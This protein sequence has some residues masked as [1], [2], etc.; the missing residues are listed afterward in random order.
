MRMRARHDQDTILFDESM[1]YNLRYGKL[2][3][4]RADALDAAS[5]VGLDPTAQ[6]MPY[7]YDTRVGERGLTLSGGERQRVAIARAL[8]KDPP[9]MLYD[10]ATSVIA[11]PWLSSL[12]PCRLSSR[13]SSCLPSRP[14]PI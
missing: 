8:L 2:E 6:K 13:L 14:P 5:R 3:A 10:E 11:P 12:L 9:I 1:L 4:S 7:G